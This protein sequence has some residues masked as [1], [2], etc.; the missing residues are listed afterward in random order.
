MQRFLDKWQVPLED[1]T[2]IKGTLLFLRFEY[3]TLE[4]VIEETLLSNIEFMEERVN[5]LH[6]SCS[7]GCI[8]LVK[9]LLSMGMNPNTCDKHGR[10]TLYWSIIVY[11]RGRERKLS[12]IKFLLEL[13]VNYKQKDDQGKTF[14]DYVCEDLY[15]DYKQ[16][17]LDC[18]Q[19]MELR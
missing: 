3:D 10:N 9:L 13:G 19:E 4:S 11:M 5:S 1:Q 12:L 15:E 7:I 8:P 14:I 18:I 6:A 17:I 2:E 16:E